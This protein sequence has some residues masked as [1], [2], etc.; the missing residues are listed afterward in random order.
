MQSGQ[1]IAPCVSRKV[2]VPS[3]KEYNVSLHFGSKHDVTKL[4]ADGEKVK[5][6]NFLKNLTRQ[7][8]FLRKKIQ[9][10]RWLLRLALRFLWKLLLAVS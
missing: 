9:K 7:K 2:A 3:P 6:S 1:N 4:D 10:V 5:L 8:Q